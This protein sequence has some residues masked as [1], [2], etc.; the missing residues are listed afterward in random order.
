MPEHTYDKH[1]GW[2]L[3]DD[4]DLDSERARKYPPFV[5]EGKMFGTADDLPAV[6][7]DSWVD[8]PGLRGR[9]APLPTRYLGREL[10]TAKLGQS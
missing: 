9:L 2:L 7:P 4:F 8:K 6:V 1:Y 5:Y 10:K 3:D